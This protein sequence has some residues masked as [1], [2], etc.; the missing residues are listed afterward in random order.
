MSVTMN[1]RTFLLLSE[2]HYPVLTNTP[3]QAYLSLTSFWCMYY[4]SLFIWSDL[5]LK[6]CLPFVI[7]DF[8]ARASPD[9]ILDLSRSNIICYLREVMLT[10][11]Y[12]NYHSEWVIVCVSNQ[13]NIILDFFLSSM[14]QKK[15]DYSKI[16][17]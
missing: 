6:Y 5:Q 17:L 8:L 7:S 11:K 13:C 12:R 15:Y 1:Y 3:G 9:T 10:I 4:L 16:I 2:H 14:Y